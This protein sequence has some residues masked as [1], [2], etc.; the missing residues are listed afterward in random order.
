MTI[1]ESSFP[2]DFLIG[3]I[4]QELRMCRDANYAPVTLERMRRA[5]VA[6]YADRENRMRAQDCNASAA[7]AKHDRETLEI[8]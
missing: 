4:T 7:L 8:K 1:N 2:E 3:Q 5:L 6:Y